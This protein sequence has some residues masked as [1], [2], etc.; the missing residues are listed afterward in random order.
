MCIKLHII[1]FIVLYLLSHNVIWN[2]G[3]YTDITP[4]Y[5][6][7]A[8]ESFELNYDTMHMYRQKCDLFLK[9]IWHFSF[10]F[11]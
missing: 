6:A 4:Y 1:V 2:G 8:V 11:L 9:Y 10:H 3:V 5:C 7:Q